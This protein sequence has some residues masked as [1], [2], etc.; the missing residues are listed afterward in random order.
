MLFIM[1]VY[2]TQAYLSGL[3]L[4]VPG[5]SS[6]QHF[7]AFFDTFFIHIVT[8]LLKYLDPTIHTYFVLFYNS[9]AE[10]LLVFQK[11]PLR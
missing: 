11:A 7:S 8:I 9:V 5:L 3:S 1:L 6:C 2:L 10:S 4:D